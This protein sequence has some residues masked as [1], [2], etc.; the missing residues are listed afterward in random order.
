[1]KNVTKN[2]LSEKQAP[3][4]A[5]KDAHLRL[6]AAGNER[7]D[8]NPVAGAVDFQSASLADRLHA[9]VKAAALQAQLD[10]LN[11][12]AEEALDLD[13]PDEMEEPETPYER[14]SRILDERRLLAAQAKL[15]AKTAEINR[16]KG[17]G[18][19]EPKSPPAEP[20]PLDPPP[21]PAERTLVDLVTQAVKSAMSKK[22]ET[23]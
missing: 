1:M 21:E 12:T 22:P 11:E 3:K 16:L 6:D 18:P 15:D 13:D 2:V 9:Q 20:N 17:R 14:E 7:L 4:R 8:P 5:R 19:A 23:S 10:Q